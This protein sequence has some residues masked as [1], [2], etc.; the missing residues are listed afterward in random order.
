MLTGN[1][2]AIAIGGIIAVMASVIVSRLVW[3]RVM[4]NPEALWK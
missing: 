2:V 1:L 4:L 3:S